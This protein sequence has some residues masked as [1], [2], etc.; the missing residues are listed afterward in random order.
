MSKAQLF[1]CCFWTSTAWQKWGVPLHEIDARSTPE[2][3]RYE[4][5][6]GDTMQIT[7]HGFEKSN[8]IHN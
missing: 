6:C 3:S 8:M 7:W 4:I 5:A 1:E 2:F